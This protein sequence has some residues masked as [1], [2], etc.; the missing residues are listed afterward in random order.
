MIPPVPV[1]PNAKIAPPEKQKAALVAY[2]N[3]SVRPDREDP[4]PA[5]ATMFRR[6]PSTV[7]VLQNHLDHVCKRVSASRAVSLPVSGT[8]RRSSAL[9]CLCRPI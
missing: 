7:L 1:S 9:R 8:H 2:Q 4:A 6:V 5:Y 3:T